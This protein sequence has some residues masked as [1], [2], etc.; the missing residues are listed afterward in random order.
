MIGDGDNFQEAEK[1]IGK[2]SRIKLIHSKRDINKYYQILD[3]FILPSFTEPFGIVLIEAGI[4]KIP[5]IASNADGIPEVVEN[6]Q[7]GILFDKT[8][9]SKLGEIIVQLVQ[10]TIDPSEYIFNFHQKITDNF[11]V[12]KIIPQY[13]DNYCGMLGNEKKK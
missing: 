9:F 11:V 5:V 13:E 12:K 1:L 6:K 7:D 10:K 2:E 4:N 3:Y 8:D